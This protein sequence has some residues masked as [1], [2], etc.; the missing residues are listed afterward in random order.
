M[1]AFSSQSFRVN[2]V[3]GTGHFLSHYYQLCLP[4]M[5]LAWQVAFDVS[6]AELGLSLA[7][8]SCAT[9]LLQTPVGFLV[10]RH[11]ARPFLVGGTLL[12]TLSISALGFTTSYWQVLLLCLLS[13][14]GNSV[15][16]PTDYAI[17]ST[18][19]ERSRMG[20]SFA[21]HTF[22]G[23]LGSMLAPPVTA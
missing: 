22:S 10:D 17:L 7:L 13:G 9:G 14:V 18:S 8:M 16:H 3:I 21:L 5:F 23:N 1:T 6:F 11:G 19:V 2:A 15:I 4:P 12:M 20:R